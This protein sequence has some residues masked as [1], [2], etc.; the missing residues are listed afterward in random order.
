MNPTKRQRT[1]DLLRDRQWHSNTEFVNAGCGYRYGAHIHELRKRG[2]LIEA[3][4]ITFARWEYRLR[5]LSPATTGQTRPKRNLKAENT[6][7]RLAISKA[8]SE[9]GAYP[10][11][12]Q[13]TLR[14][15]L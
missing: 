2:Y 10:R 4:S 11:E 9:I 6:R 14:A 7:L 8:L 5:R 3:R 12:A 13:V 1:L 15:A